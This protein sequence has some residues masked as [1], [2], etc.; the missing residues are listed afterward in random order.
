MQ[1]IPLTGKNAHGRVTRIDDGDLE[2]VTRYRWRVH[3]SRVTG[4]SWAVAYMSLCGGKYGGGEGISNF[5]MHTLI[6]GF[7]LTDHRN[8][9]GLD[10]QRSNLREA[11]YAQNAWNRR[12]KQ[13]SQTGFKGVNWS[14]DRT[15]RWQARIMKDG[16]RCFLGNFDTPVEAALAYDAAARALFGE[17]AW[18]NFPGESLEREPSPLIRHCARPDCGEEFQFRLANAIYCSRRCAS[19]MSKRRVRAQKREAVA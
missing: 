17:F 7:A 11:T 13:G 15:R 2:L 18:V 6:T 19:I 16:K 3:E 1:E 14:G 10:N 4:L 8:G 12:A 5:P 9:D